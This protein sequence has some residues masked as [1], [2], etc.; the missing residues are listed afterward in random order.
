[1]KS[2]FQKKS[3]EIVKLFQQTMR[4]QMKQERKGM[5]SKTP[6]T[7]Q[8]REARPRIDPSDVKFELES[9]SKHIAKIYQTGIGVHHERCTIVAV[10]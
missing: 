9:K 10:K 3:K 6:G 4:D 5:P 7:S 8:A 2:M 1:M